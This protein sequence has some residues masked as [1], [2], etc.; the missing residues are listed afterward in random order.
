MDELK[1]IPQHDLTKKDISHISII[2]III[3]ILGIILYATGNNYT[4]YSTNEGYKIFMDGISS[5]GRDIFVILY[6]CFF[7]FVYDKEFSRRLINLFLLSYF[8]NNILKNIIKDL[9][10][11][12]NCVDERYCERNYGFPSGHAQTT[13]AFFGYIYLEM[14]ERKERRV[15]KLIQA[16]SIFCMLLVPFSRLVIGVHDVDDVFGGA[17]IGLVYLVIFYYIEPKFGKLIGVRSVSQQIIISLIGAF[18]IFGSVLIAFP[19]AAYDYAIVGGILIGGAIAYPLEENYIKYNPR[20]LK[21]KQSIL[22]FLLGAFITFLVY[23]GFEQIFKFFVF[24]PAFS[25]TIQFFF[26]T[27]VITLCCPWIFTQLFKNTS[28]KTYNFGS[29]KY[30]PNRNRDDELLYGN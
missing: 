12:M 24:D 8:T 16:Y 7:Y 13:I 28:V 10:P 22:V 30:D 6:F 17:V 25:R 18:V 9:R 21:G 11:P 2:A 23:F 4:F 5:L 14:Q 20:L 29:R 1:A 26:V 19:T 3:T 27:N 15:S